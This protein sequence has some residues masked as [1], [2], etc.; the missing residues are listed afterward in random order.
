MA[1]GSNRATVH[2]KKISLTPGRE[3]EAAVLSPGEYTISVEAKAYGSARKKLRVI[4]GGDGKADSVLCASALPRAKTGGTLPSGS[5]L[6]P[7]KAC[8]EEGTFVIPLDAI[9]DRHAGLVGAKALSLARM[10]RIGV[11]IPPGFCVTGAAYREHLTSGGLM[12]RIKAALGRL[13]SD[14]V[15]DARSTLSGIRESIIE[16]PL[17]E[18]TSDAIG[19]QYASLGEGV[20]A[21][22][23][24]ATAEDL[25]ERSFAGQYDTYLGVPSLSQCLDTLRRCWASLWTDRA[26]DYREK[27]GI[28]HLGVDMAVIV[29]KLV[30]ADASGVLFTADPVRGRKDRI[31]VEGSFGLGEAIVQG[32]VTPDRFVLTKRS[33]KIVDR[34]ISNKTLEIVPDTRGG[35]RERSVSRQRDRRPCLGLRTLKRLARL[36]IRIEKLFGC[37][38]D[39]EWAVSNGDVFVLQ[40]R[41]ITVLPQAE[42]KSWEERQVWT[43]ANLGEVAPDV[44]TPFTLSIYESFRRTVV[45]PLLRRMG[46]ELGDEPL[47]G[48]VA[49]RLYFSVNTI[50]GTFRHFPRPLGRAINNAFGGEQGKMFQLAKL[51]LRDDDLPDVR[52]SLLKAILFALV[53]AF[54]FVS[55]TPK[56]GSRFVAHIAKENKRLQRLHLLSM[57]NREVIGHLIREVDNLRDFMPAF[58]YV[59]PILIGLPMLDKVCRK[60]LGE[61]GGS[62][63]NSLLAATGELDSARA[64]QDLWRLAV[65]AREVAAVEE[66]ILA[67][68]DWQTTRKRVARV[69]G[70]D[71]FLRAWDQFMERHGHRTRGELE[72]FNPRWSET[73]DYVLGFVRNHIGCARKSDPLAEYRKRADQRY[74]LT[75]RC[76]QRLK[77]PLKRAVFSYLLVQAQQGAAFRENVKSEVVRYWGLLRKMALHL[78]QRFHEKGLLETPEDLF[79][80]E[81]EEV[82]L[83]ARG[84]L[85]FDVRDIIARRRDEYDKNKSVTPPHV[86]VGTFDPENFTPEDVDAD[87]DVL[88][89]MAVSPGRATGKAR[90]ILRAD[91]NEHVLP[92]EILVAPFTDSAWAPYFVSAAA[93]VVDLGGMLSH[94]SILA[95]E[96][97]IPAVVNVGPA[98]K[99][100]RTGQTVQVDG[101]RGQVSVLR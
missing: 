30:R 3:Y 11:P 99:I 58:L 93:V 19:N 32:K 35:V 61:N 97:G 46:V 16:G 41:A 75:Q 84:K 82:R 28:P 70:G 94:G 65:K 85:D 57:S 79:F 90:V 39:I 74:M 27:N 51:E 44:V 31:I 17:S 18:D 83:V 21:V 72:L 73:P 68:H 100:I 71:Q 42:A 22:R 38:Q 1:S 62:L 5:K 95:R 14:P 2:S 8:M 49:G 92:G 54:L 33:L 37:S 50:T 29:Q 24:S 80:L 26:F 7:R 13:R 6:R 69:E 60:W 78:G 25:P 47:A 76:R 86:V 53:F 66:V 12:P 34:V 45:Y 88:T 15:Q 20:V 36:A 23:S 91:T 43:N 9:E 55:H 87:A 56:K 96:Y 48:L 98:T 67:V 64:G 63:A 4:G 59:I 81:L 40:S 77:N 10:S 101:T 52:F 89:G